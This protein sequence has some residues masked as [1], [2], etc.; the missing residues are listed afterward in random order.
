MQVRPRADQRLQQLQRLMRLGKS[1]RVS[2][3]IYTVYLLMLLLQSNATAQFY[4]VY[5]HL[6][7]THVASL[8]P[9]LAPPLKQDRGRETEHQQ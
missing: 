2:V 1:I 6:L 8:G 5:T 4:T 3:A 9:P 7:N